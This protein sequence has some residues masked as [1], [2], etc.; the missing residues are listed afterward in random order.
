MKR[1]L[2]VLLCLVLEALAGCAT[3][4]VSPHLPGS[5]LRQHAVRLDRVTYVPLLVLC[6]ELAM[7]WD[8][9]RTTHVAVL[10]KHGTEVRLVVGSS[11]ILVDGQPKELDGSVR[12]HEGAVLV[13]LSFAE[14]VPFAAVP[15]PT[16]AGRPQRY[17]V[18]RLVIDPGHG[19]KD[20]GAISRQGVREKDIVL[21]VATRLKRVLDGNGIDVRLTRTDDRFLSLGRRTEIAN[22]WEADLFVSVH[23]N[24][25]RSRAMR[26]FEAYYLS[27]AIDDST[28]AL[29]AAEHALPAVGASAWSQPTT[30]LRATV[31]DLLYTENRAASI[32]LAR[33]VSEAARRRLQVKTLGV[34][35]ARFYVL[36]G[37]RMP[38]VLVEIGF[39]SNP[40]E[41]GQLARASYRQEIA[42][43][44]GEG[45]L[46]YVQE[47]HRTDGFSN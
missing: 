16:A 37:S 25:H 14:Q 35:G 44:V 46:A 7:D 2:I 19:G 33:A 36:K 1:V 23:A 3:P 24:A 43:A 17:Q 20:P 26:G 41:G 39:L 18:R 8:W 31:W 12:L 38:A 15:P 5:V 13:P 4:R 29:Q 47:Y 45:I 28:R 21:D 27:Q 9:D 42:E 32:D 40:D 22:S 10:R 11:V 30:A 34:K 6:D